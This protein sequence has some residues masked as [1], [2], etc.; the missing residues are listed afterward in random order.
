M[1]FHTWIQKGILKG[2]NFNIL[3]RD[4]KLYIK[5]DLESGTYT[6]DEFGCIN[7]RLKKYKGFHFNNDYIQTQS[8]N[9]KYIKEVEIPDDASIIVVD[10]SED[11]PYTYPIDF[12]INLLFFVSNKIT[13]K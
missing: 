13:I 2:A 12:D 8:N 4:S 11:I 1:Q 10:R 3:N 6:S 5:T 7:P 9:G